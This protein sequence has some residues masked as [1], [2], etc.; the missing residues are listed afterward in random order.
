MVLGVVALAATVVASEQGAWAQAAGQAAR[1]ARPTRRAEARRI[2]TPPKIDGLLDDAVWQQAVVIDEFTQQ[3]P[4]EGRPATERTEVRI[5][6]DEHTLF[7]GMSATDSDPLGI[8]ANEMRR[9]SNRLLDED[10]FQIILDTFQ[11]SRSGYMF[12]TNPLGGKLEQQIFQEGE[13]GRGGSVSNIN[14]NWD[15]VWNVSSRRTSRGW[16]AEIAIPM[17]TVRFP[18]T[19]SQTW[20]LNFM[21]SIR[22]K[23]ELVFW[24]PIPKGFNLMRVSMAGTLTGLEKLNR[25]LDLRI[26]PFAITGG[27]SNRT[28]TVSDNSGLRDA[29]LDVKYGVGSGL[30]LDL[31]LNTDFAQA[32]ADE[33]QIN[34]TRFSLFFPER[35]DFFLENS[36]QF[37]VSTQGLE[38]IADLFFSRRIGL[39]DAGTPIPILGGARLS[40]KTGRNTLAVMN[41]QTDKVSGREG[42]NFLVGRYSRDFLRRSKVGGLVINKES[43]N[44]E[45]FNRTFATDVTFAPLRNFTV[46]SFLAKTSSPGVTD[47]QMAFHTQAVWQDPRW[48]VF[49]EYTDIQDNFNAEVGFVPRRGIRTTKVHLERNPRPNKYGVRVFEPMINII[50]TTDQNNRL[51]TRRV[52]QML[53]TRLQNGGNITVFYNRWFEQLDLPFAVQRNVIIPPGA[54][55]FGEW[56]FIYNSNPSKRFYQQVRIAPQT[57]FDGDRLDTTLT[58]GLWATNQV[59]GEI[60]WQRNDV[61]L[62][63]GNFLVNLAI[64]RL[65][66]ALSPRMTLRSLTQFN[67]STDQLSTSVRFNYI[68]RPGSDIFLV[69]N[70]LRSEFPGALPIKNREFLVKMTYLLSR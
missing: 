18:A 46:N 42:E 55:R 70:D 60:E 10:N 30:N 47:G 38:R 69:Y 8:I 31:T 45:Q 67:S 15:G 36:G 53:G 6:Y 59:Q 26:K 17:V 34:L 25:G 4:A 51:L 13:G 5:L 27:R 66:M 14:R 19:E 52:H 44:G 32:E 50:Y 49:G 43:M 41:V 28:G 23:N 3:E 57:F 39:S 56:N 16:D 33:Q 40:G 48:N 21:R 61:N 12:V 54:Y 63:H 64:M 68:Y 37:N 7:I 58:L 20:G 65:N 62:P 29:G 35:R 9:D 24:S 1:A 2:A 22:R 11:D